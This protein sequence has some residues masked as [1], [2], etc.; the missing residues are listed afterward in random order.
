MIGLW[1]GFGTYC[2]GH[3]ATCFFERERARKITKVLIVPL[4]MLVG[5]FC[6]LRRELV[7][8]GLA[9]GW[10]G[11]VFLLYPERKQCFVVGA[12]AFALG[13]LSYIAATVQTLLRSGGLSEISP[14][15]YMLHGLLGVAL[16]V[17]AWTKLRK[18]LGFVAFLGAGYFF[19]LTGA[20]LLSMAAGAWLLTLAF[21]MFLVSDITLTV[22]R[23]F[24]TIPRDN[25]YIMLTYILAQVLIC[26]AFLG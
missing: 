5:V 13:H 11:D 8:L 3:L 12:G 17:F 22:C 2:F 25:F 19:V 18:H 1:L 21:G 14:V 10:V 15:L 23:F 7:V 6:G 16:F 4:L 26:L 20:W 24:K 9:F